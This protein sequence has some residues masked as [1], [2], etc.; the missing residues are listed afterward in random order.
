MRPTLR[1]LTGARAGATFTPG[2]DRFL[3]GRHTDAEL[4]FSAEQDLAVSARHAEFINLEG[5]WCIRD[6]G[7]RNG[8]FVNGRRITSDRPL[9]E[10]DRVAFGAGGPVV[11]VR[12][13][14]MA[15]PHFGESPTQRLA[16]TPRDGSRAGT[17]VAGARRALRRHQLAATA[18]VATVAIV[19][20]VL[21]AS[22]V[23]RGRNERAIWQAERIALHAQIDSLLASTAALD[24]SLDAEVTGLRAA[25]RVAEER[26]TGLREEL[27]A[28]KQDGERA[29]ALRRQ[30]FAATTAL[31]RQQLAGSLDFAM[32]GARNRSAVA[33][34]WIENTDGVRV[35]GTAFALRADGTMLTNRHLLTGVDDASRPR[36]IAIRF[37]DSEQT[38][39]ARIVALDSVSDLAAIRVQ[40]VL[41]DVPAVA[42]INT[43]SDT[44][45]PGAPLALIGFPLG[46]GL[47]DTSRARPLISAGVLVHA[48]A[49]RLELQGLGAAGASG[50]PIIDGDGSV[51][52][53]LFGGRTEA[54]VQILSG[55]S[56]NAIASFL[57]R[58]PAQ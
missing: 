53:V 6:L 3:A 41:G 1:I 12:F 40:N 34:L 44:L 37:A 43:R 28:T 36:R 21:V 18:G 50:S 26:L 11:E 16:P 9:R 2:F 23:S 39:P 30:L 8:T 27:D 4:R 25:L 38:F 31:Q 35:T 49:D 32:I 14:P 51:V 56:A 20:A 10:G 17:A 15:N 55:V 52:G 22:I 24:S 33:M 5:A 45:P 48:S 29:A 54:G 47:G 7:S 46:G 19:A 58:I 42:N 13:A 57:E